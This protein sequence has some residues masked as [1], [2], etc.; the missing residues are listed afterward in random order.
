MDL[1]YARLSRAEKLP[2]DIQRR[3]ASTSG[4]IIIETTN[5]T[6]SEN[7]IPITTESGIRGYLINRFGPFNEIEIE[8]E[9]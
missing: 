9:P 6:L 1:K 8:D 3:I 5:P 4:L 2:S 7:F